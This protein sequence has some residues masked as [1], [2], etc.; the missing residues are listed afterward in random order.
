M[1][2][3]NLG[4]AAHAQLVFKLA[5]ALMNAGIMPDATVSEKTASEPQRADFDEIQAKEEV[6]SA[7]KA[8]AAA[9]QAAQRSSKRVTNVAAKKVSAKAAK[10]PAVARTVAQTQAK[11]G[12]KSGSRATKR[13]A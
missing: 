6:A 10:A 1:L 9:R 2:G 8:K 3:K 7:H 11:A 5:Y 4:N 12:K 13:A